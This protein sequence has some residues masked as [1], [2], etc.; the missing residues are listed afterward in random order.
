MPSLRR[1]RGDQRR[2]TILTA[3]HD[4][5]LDTPPTQWAAGTQDLSEP[6]HAV[7]PWTVVG[8]T[9]AL[10]L[11]AVPHAMFMVGADGRIEDANARAEMLVGYARAELVGRLIDGLISDL[12]APA[13]AQPAER[14]EGVRF[15]PAATGVC[16]HH[17]SGREV[18]VEVL[19]CPHERGSLVAHVNPI[20]GFVD[21][22]DVAELVHDLR[23]PLTTI[24]L[25]LEL[26]RARLGEQDSS[27][28]TGALAR[29]T[30]NIH[31]LDRM[32]QDVLDSSAHDAGQLVLRREPTEL[33]ALL[34]RVLARTLAERDRGRVFLEAAGSISI[35]IDALRIERVV[36][37]LIHNAL[38]F[39]P[40]ASRI[41]VS[42]DVL[43]AG[44]RVSVLDTGPGM[45]AEESSY[46]FDKYRRAAGARLH[47]GHGLGLYVCKEIVEAHGGRIGVESVRG[48]GSSFFFELPVT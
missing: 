28:L 44:A 27:R 45:T 46:A 21:A 9:R 26:L 14:V 2:E 32:V 34:E 1:S 15:V 7:P 20:S 36:E 29:I 18:P 6:G 33:R 17:R 42:L 41:V 24:G 3:G 12:G 11:A 25:D 10:E 19:I 4:G 8:N 40:R 35:S 47:E 37:N 48:V 23:N 5:E 39:A 16:V 13:V 38:K 31:F 43:E 30:R 22:S